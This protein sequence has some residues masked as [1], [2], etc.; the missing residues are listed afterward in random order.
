MSVAYLIIAHDNPQLLKRAIGVLACEDCAFFLHIDQKS[1]IAKFSGIRG[2]SVA[3]AEKRLPVYWGG[4]SQ[5]RATLLLMQEALNAGQGYDYLVLLSGSDYPL[6]SGKYIRNFFHENRGKEFINVVKVP[7]EEHGVPL[8]KVTKL[9]FEPDKPI[10][11]FAA[12]ALGKCGLADRDFKKYLGPLEPY[13]GDTWWS[14][15][16]EACQYIL[17]FVAKN[18]QV[19]EYFQSTLTS[20][21]SFFH[22]I[23]GNSVFAPR[24]ARS[25]HYIDWSVPGLHPAMISER[26]VGAFEIQEKVWVDDIWGS[27]EAL[28]TRKL[29]DERLDLARR[30]DEMIAGKE[31]GKFYGAD[32]ERCQEA[33]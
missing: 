7:S 6:R 4:F 21:E 15:T 9:G 23:L 28:F 12:R 17:E 27:G 31:R 32:A 18:R 3:F 2:E 13:A 20:D 33:M 24:F 10:R 25:V 19:D 16:Q 29:S 22:T 1:D 30:I 11:R 5:V 14:L 8:S 26:H